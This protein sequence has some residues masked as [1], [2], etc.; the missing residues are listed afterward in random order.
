MP[1]FL[2][3]LPGGGKAAGIW[4]STDLTSSQARSA[5][6]KTRPKTAEQKKRGYEKPWLSGSRTVSKKLTE[7]GH[8]NEKTMPEHRKVEG[9]TLHYSFCFFFICVDHICFYLYALFYNLNEKAELSMFLEHEGWHR[10]IMA[11]WKMQ[12][13]PGWVF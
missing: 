9:F 3:A 13:I 4:S 2:V 11:R 10:C 12:K 1:L 7:T 5:S 8:R 6:A